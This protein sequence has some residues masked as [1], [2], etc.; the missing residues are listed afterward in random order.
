[1]PQSVVG[2]SSGE[3]AAAF[4]SGR[5][6]LADAIKA[7]FYRGRAAVNCKEKAEVG[8]GMLAV[9]LG[10]KGA[11]PFLQKHEGSAW[12]ACFNS[13]SSVTIVR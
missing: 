8:V 10:A 6:S 5:L 3:I 7:A 2:H 12:I 13:P 9:G 1:M 4:A 11:T